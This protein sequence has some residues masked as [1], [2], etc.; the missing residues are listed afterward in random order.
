MQQAPQL[1]QDSITGR[2]GMS[3]IDPK[4]IGSVGEHVWFWKTQFVHQQT[5]LHPLFRRVEPKRGKVAAGFSC[6]PLSCPEWP[7][8]TSESKEL[9]LADESFEI[10][11]F[12]G[13]YAFE[14][15]AFGSA[16]AAGFA[17][18]SST[19]TGVSRGGIRPGQAS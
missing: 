13:T 16:S 3:E 6:W 2:L 7:N 18:M 8:L 12:Y 5:R 17:G 14:A 10:D 11:R 4:G 1:S 9:I 15:S 19:I